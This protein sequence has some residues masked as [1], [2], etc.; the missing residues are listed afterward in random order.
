MSRNAPAVF[1]VT[2]APFHAE[3][4]G[5]GDLDV[6]DVTR[7]PE[8]FENRVG[9]TQNQNV[10][11]GFLAEKMIDPIGL[12]FGKCIV[13]RPDSVPAAEARS[14]PNGFS[15]ITRAQ[16]PSFALVQSRSFQIFQDR[17]ELLRR[18]R[19]IKKTIA[20]RA[21]FLVD[22]IEAFRQ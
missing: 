16:L 14:R 22:L 3:R 8:R 11:R 1:V 7:V 20:A 4:F 18:R 19:E 21:A 12:I 15:M 9:K 10:L 17:L 5:R 6:I 13:I 2:G